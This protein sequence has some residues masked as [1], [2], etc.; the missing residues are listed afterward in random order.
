[1]N[2]AALLLGFTLGWSSPALPD[3]EQNYPEFEMGTTE[4]SWVGSVMCLGA[5][6]GCVIGATLSNKLGRKRTIL[7]A[8][9]MFV[10]GY[11]LI[12][13]ANGM[14]MLYAGRAILGVP[15]GIF[16]TVTMVYVGEI[17][18]SEYRGMLSSSFQLILTIGMLLVNLLGM[19][20]NFKWL[21]VVCIVISV[22]SFVVT[23]PMPESPVYLFSKNR[24]EEAEK[25]MHWLRGEAYDTT[26]WKREIQ[27]SLEEARANK[28]D[29][30][31]LKQRY[32]VLPLCLGILL[33]IFQQLSGI[34]VVVFYTATIF[35][36]AK[37]SLEPLAA[38]CVVM[39]LQVVVTFICSMVIDKAG[40]KILLFVSALMMCLSTAALGG[41]FY[42]METVSI[43]N[44]KGLLKIGQLKI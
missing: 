40:R 32:V 24:D 3:I 13:P 29:I 33:M 25:A 31:E 7:I 36:Y 14:A 35:G 2:T 43:E 10:L 11:A 38:S 27:Q 21:S 37:S 1:M 30:N 22:I 19:A 28:L 4:K 39:S 23:L 16:C 26:E 12:I 6:L 15:V 18:M 34:N 41:Y 42:V 5:I 20:L 44:I 17:S 8:S 9:P